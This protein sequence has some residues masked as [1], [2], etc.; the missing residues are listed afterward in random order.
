MGA[1][2]TITN[3]NNV[4]AGTDADA[5]NII[6]YSANGGSNL[7]F[8]FPFTAGAIPFINR[9][10]SVTNLFYMNN[11]LHDI[12]YHFG[13]DELAGNFQQNNYGNGGSGNDQVKAEAMDGSG[14]NNANFSTPT[15]GSAPRMQMYLWTNSNPDRDASFD[16]GVI[17][18]EYGHGVSNRLTGG[19]A[20]SS[21]LNNIQSGGMGEGWSDYFGLMLTMEPGDNGANARGIGT[22]LLGQTPSGAGIRRKQYSTD[23]IIDPLELGAYGTSGTTAYGITRSTQVHNT[24]EIWCS[25]LWDMSWNLIDDLGFDNTWANTSSGNYIALRLVIQGMKLQPCNPGFIDARNAILNADTLLY[26]GAHACRIWQAFARRGMGINASQGASSSATTITAGFNLPAGCGTLPEAAFKSNVKSLSCSNTVSFTNQSQFSTS[27]LWSFGDATS[28]TLANPTHTYSS[29]GNYNVKLTATNASG[30]DTITHTI[31]ASQNPDASFNMLYSSYVFEGSSVTFVNQSTEACSYFMDFGDGT[32]T[33]GFSSSH[34]YTTAGDYDVKLVATNNVGSDSVTHVVHVVPL[35]VRARFYADKT[36]VKCD[37]SVVFT[38]TSQ[39]ATSYLWDFGDQTTSTLQSPPP[40][41][42]PYAGT[43][44]VKLVAYDGIFS[45]STTISITVQSAFTATATATPSSIC[46]GDSVQLNVTNSTSTGSQYGF[47][48]IP[49]APVAGTGTAVSLTDDQLSASLPIGFSFSYYGFPYTQFKICSNGFIT[50]NT[51]ASTTSYGVA[52][53]S[54]ASPNNFI[55]L[56]KADLN[57]ANAGSAINYFTTGIAPNRILVVNFG[58]SYYNQTTKPVSVQALLYETS[59]IIELHVDTISSGLTSVQ[60]IE[61]LGGTVGVVIPGRN[62]AIFSANNEG[63]RFAPAAFSYNWMP[64]NLSGATQTFYP[65]ASTIYTVVVADGTGCLAVA[66]LPVTVNANPVPSITGS[67][68][69][70]DGSSTTLSSPAAGIIN[71]QYASTVINF[72]S[73]YTPTDW[74]ANQILGAPDVYPFYGSIPQAW[75]PNGDP[76]EFIE[77]G[78]ASAS[79]INFIDIYETYMPGAIDTVYIKNPATGLFEVVYSTT[80]ALFSN[81]TARILHISFPMTTFNVSE[82]RIAINCTS[83]Q[84]WNEIDAVAIGTQNVYSYLWSTGATTPTISVSTAGTFTVT[85]T[86]GNGCSGASPSVSTTV[87]VCTLNLNLKAFIEG[88]YLPGG[89]MQAVLFNAGIVSD[90][91]ICDSIIVELHDQLNPVTIVSSNTVAL[92]TNGWAQLTLPGAFIGGNYY[93]VI[94]SRNTI[95]TWSKL[96]VTLGNNTT[97]DFT[98]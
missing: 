93:I 83:I 63:W 12:L 60:G 84:S 19:P 31:Y 20:N 15:D 71:Q 5:N 62:S 23:M 97:F 39:L 90:P 32:S 67:L 45:D 54:T 75:S 34:T 17:V 22:Y 86:D 40:H 73:Q 91:L 47:S 42:Y 88:Y 72:S 66:T 57:P 70:C 85:V 29:A 56:L 10:A 37:E 3:G 49:Y 94:R 24:G 58:T 55:A 27:Y 59:N 77:L 1:D 35:I 46:A 50:F 14:T 36:T 43:Y 9:D 74:S 4:Y 78:F 44:I 28:S 6:E 7:D 25:A 80:A 13:F 11:R 2:Y 51:T 61:N 98:Q 48:S 18:H 79:P 87:N 41:Q 64:G 38:N 69:I 81:S 96:P 16:N 21:C 92:H 33:P 82:I 26:G 30:N 53:P 68:S 76:R 65:A 95:E 8:N 89:S 52:I